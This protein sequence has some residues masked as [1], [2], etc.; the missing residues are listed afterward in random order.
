MTELLE[1]FSTPAKLEENKEECP[2][3]PGDKKGYKTYAGVENC[4]KLLKRI[5]KNPEKLLDLQ[6]GCEPKQGDAK[7]QPLHNKKPNKREA[8]CDDGSYGY[9][10]YQAHHL[11]SGNQIMKGHEI[12]D[13]IR[14]SPANE[15]EEDTGYSINN[16][17]NG[18][19]L[20]SMPRCFYSKKR[21]RNWIDLSD[22]EKLE[23]AE[24]PM[25]AG[26]GQFHLGSH[27]IVDQDD[28]EEKHSRSYVKVGKK[29]L[30]KICDYVLL[31]KQS[32][33]LCNTGQ[34]NGP[35]YK[36]PYK[37]N[38]YLDHASQELERGL[39]R[40]IAQWDFFV[41]DLALR[42]KKRHT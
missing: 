9:Y 17:D 10:S 41:S 38:K 8:F 5:M 34:N 32:C 3:C 25:L 21:P 33:Y 39:L 20:P 28:I 31:W 15:I 16:S 29:E 4:S 13:W 30:K 7:P 1:K 35:P 40:P 14:K 42:C 23:I 18:L 2:F 22:D 24:K 36:P 11:I 27:N 19:W 26:E 6:P 37:V 12:E